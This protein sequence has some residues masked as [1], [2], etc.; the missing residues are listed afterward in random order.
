MFKFKKMTSHTFQLKDNHVSWLEE[1]ALAK[2]E[3]EQRNV[4]LSEVMRDVLQEKIDSE[5]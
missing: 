3:K 2:S 5:K 4:S 1:K